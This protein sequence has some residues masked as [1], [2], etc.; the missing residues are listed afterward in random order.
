MKKRLKFVE[1]INIPNNNMTD[2]TQ[3]DIK[4]IEL[5]KNK[6]LTT[7]QNEI[8]NPSGKQYSY[9]QNDENKTVLNNKKR[10]LFENVDSNSKKI[11]LSQNELPANLSGKQYS[12]SQNIKKR[13]ANDIID[14]NSKKVKLD[15]KRKVTDNLQNPS[16]KLR[17]QLR[18]WVEL[19]NTSGK[20]YSYS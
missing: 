3:N 18:D 15:L 12:Y 7:P 19:A 10:K 6:D 13:K 8:A 1:D 20:Q 2:I 5:T 16:K 17:Y 9:S 14:N 11:K 4:E